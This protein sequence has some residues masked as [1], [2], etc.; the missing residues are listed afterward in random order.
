MTPVS[1]PLAA[2]GETGSVP[3]LELDG[4]KEERG[5]EKEEGEGEGKKEKGRTGTVGEELG[6]VETPNMEG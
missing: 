3:K 2:A 1:D 4:V 5:A 6:R